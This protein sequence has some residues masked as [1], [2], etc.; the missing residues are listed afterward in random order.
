M[1]S[2]ILPFQQ[3]LSIDSPIICYSGAL[4][5][6]SDDKDG[7]KPVIDSIHLSQTDVQKIYKII[8]ELFPSVSLNLY[9]HD[10]WVVRD[11]KMNG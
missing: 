11:K 1:P 8:D 5:L 6:G 9:S 7:N 2:G 10:Q 3:I 4:I